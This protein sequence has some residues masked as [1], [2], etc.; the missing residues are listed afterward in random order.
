MQEGGQADVFGKE[1]PPEEPVFYN[2]GDRVA[3]FCWKPSFFKISG[4]YESYTGSQ[5]PMHFYINYS[6]ALN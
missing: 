2:Q 3:I 4:E 1:I 6:Y 5:T